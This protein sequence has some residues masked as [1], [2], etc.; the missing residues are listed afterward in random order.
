MTMSLNKNHQLNSYVEEK[1][2]VDLKESS[3]RMKIFRVNRTVFT[4]QLREYS[5]NVGENER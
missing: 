1:Y 4:E 2:L 3:D 5:M